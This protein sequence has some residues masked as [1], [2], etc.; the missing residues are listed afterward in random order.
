M[1][2]AQGQA[3]SKIVTRHWPPWFRAGLQTRAVSA[4][5]ADRQNFLPLFT[6]LRRS[7]ISK[8]LAGSNDRFCL[9]IPADR[10][11]EDYVRFRLV[12]RPPVAYARRK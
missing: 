4:G 12:L 7:F 1:C 5:Q 2:L 6:F 10:F 3:R 11:L 8:R 9:R